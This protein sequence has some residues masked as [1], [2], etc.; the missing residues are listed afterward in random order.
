MA[1]GGTTSA[2]VKPMARGVKRALLGPVN[3]TVA[4][5]A[6]VGAAALGSLPLLALGGAA[7]AALVAWDLSSPA[8]WRKVVGAAPAAGRELPRP[9][10]VFDAET[11]AALER[12]HAA[13]AAIGE[14]VAGAEATMA[15]SLASLLHTLDELD[16]RVG[17]LVARSDELSRYLAR[18]DEAGLRRELDELAERARRAPDAETRRHYDDARAA[19]EEQLRTRGEIA[20][21]RERLVA[22]LTQIVATLEGIPAKLMKMRALDAQ[23]ADDVSGDVG[24]ELAE[25]NVGLQAFEETLE[26]LVAEPA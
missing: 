12:V 9:R 13:R 23:A 24:R 20:T 2:T 8:F 18:D 25:M 6:A 21:A 14:V 3:L 17:R 5:A 4:G 19:R 16:Q 7:Y 15:A 10:E 1:A 11:R 22:N 26:S